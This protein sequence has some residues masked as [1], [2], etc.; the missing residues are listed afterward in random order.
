M[1]LSKE[2]LQEIETQVRGGFEAR[3]RIIEIFCEE[4]YAPDELDPDEVE[5]AVDAAIAAHESEKPNWP[6]VTDC[7][8][9]DAVFEALNK[10]GIVSL[11]NAGY[12]QSDGYSDCVEVY[13]ERLKR[14]P[15][16]GHCFYQGQ[17]LERAVH[18]QGLCLAFGPMN[19]EEEETKGPE[20]GR[21]IAAELKRA[22]FTVEWD[23]TFSKRI[24][25]QDIEWK[26]R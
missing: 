18:G 17:D 7:D 1:P 3:D 5:A 8:R 21:I 10:Q 22:G 26:R 4:M 19:P 24:F 2:T 20:I 9:L 14:E 11:Q 23:G 6:E 12:T 16:T 15:I 25:V 13:H